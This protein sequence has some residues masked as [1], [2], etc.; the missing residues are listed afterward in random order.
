MFNFPSATNPRLVSRLLAPSQVKQSLD[1]D[2]KKNYDITEECVRFYRALQSKYQV[3]PRSLTPPQSYN[4]YH[5]MFTS[6]IQD[7]IVNYL[8]RNFFEEF[9]TKKGEW[10]ESESCK[11]ECFKKASAWYLAAYKYINSKYNSYRTCSLDTYCY[12]T[13]SCPL[14]GTCLST[15]ET[16]VS[17]PSPGVLVRCC[18]NS[19]DRAGTEQFPPPQSY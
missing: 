17:S 10:M 18:V 19:L 6:L 1:K 4:K 16:C 14:P 13:M 3:P 2:R 5:D 15:E 12:V 8:Q 7:W 11:T 9:N